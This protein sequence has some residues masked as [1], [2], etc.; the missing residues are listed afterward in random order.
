MEIRQMKIILLP[1]LILIFSLNIFSFREGENKSFSLV[2]ESI[3]IEK[4]DNLSLNTKS[5]KKLG[6][7]NY[8]LNKV[9]LLVELTRSG[10]DLISFDFEDKFKI[11]KNENDNLFITDGGLIISYQNETIRE[12]IEIKYGLSLKYNLNGIFAYKPSDFNELNDLYVN[13]KNE[14]GVLSINYNFIDPYVRP[15]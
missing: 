2:E 4:K 10:K 15:R 11:V 13:L 7:Y 3:V 6:N 8:S 5:L 14:N 1:F 9:N 12:Q